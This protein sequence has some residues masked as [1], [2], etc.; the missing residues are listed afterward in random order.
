MHIYTCMCM[1]V[2]QPQHVVKSKV[3]CFTCWYLT[4]RG[5]MC[6]HIPSTC[7][8]DMQLNIYNST[9]E[10]LSLDPICKKVYLAGIKWSSCI[11]SAVLTCTFSYA[12]NL[13]CCVC[14]KIVV[15]TS[16]LIGQPEHFWQWH[17]M[18]NPLSQLECRLRLCIAYWT[19]FCVS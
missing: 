11:H 19:H 6:V 16:M 14:C 2:R 17:L 10:T 7:S 15:P 1:C 13:F 8:T 12:V 4:V 3:L 5:Y 18:V 9:V